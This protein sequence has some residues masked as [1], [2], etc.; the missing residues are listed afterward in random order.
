MVPRMPPDGGI[1]G[2][3]SEWLLDLADQVR[4]L[5]PP[6]RY[7]S[8]RFWRDKTEL[9]RG[10]TIWRM[11]SRGGW[12]VYDFRFAFGAARHRRHTELNPRN[13]LWHSLKDRLS[14]ML[15]AICAYLM[16]RFGTACVS[17]QRINQGTRSQPL[18]LIALFLCVPCFEI[19]NLFFK[20]AHAF[21]QRKLVRLGRNCV[22]LGGKDLSLQFDSLMPNNVGIVRRYHQIRNI[23]GRLESRH[24][25]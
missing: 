6:G 8:E 25:A 5:D 4:R 15:I 24:S 13:I 3:L 23:A 2:R 22:L 16:R 21:K 1:A 10:R 18:K 20:V 7:D 9:A 19:S 11:T 12:L 14:M 17:L